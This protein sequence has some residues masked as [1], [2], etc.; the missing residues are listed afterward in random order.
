MGTSLECKAQAVSEEEIETSGYTEE[1]MEQHQ[2]QM[3]E[4]LQIL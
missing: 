2:E 4:D 1:E 3:L